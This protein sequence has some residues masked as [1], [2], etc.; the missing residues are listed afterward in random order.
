MGCQ[1]QADLSAAAGF[2]YG[3]VWLFVCSCNIFAWWTA[4]L[5]S[6]TGDEKIVLGSVHGS[7]SAGVHQGLQ[8]SWV[9]AV[10]CNKAQDDGMALKSWPSGPSAAV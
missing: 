3:N 2:V 5:L 8:Q 7:E 6:T 1:R 4:L 9:A 10:T